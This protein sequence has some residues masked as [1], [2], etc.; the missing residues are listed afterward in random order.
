M[1]TKITHDNYTNYRDF[2]LRGLTI[3]EL[4]NTMPYCLNEGNVESRF[5]S[6]KEDFV[7]YYFNDEEDELAFILKRHITKNEWHIQQIRTV[8]ENFDKLKKEIIPL[9]E[10]ISIEKNMPIFI[11]KMRD[12]KHDFEEYLGITKVD[13]C[14]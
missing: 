9:I 3:G 8:S 1:W 6:L 10:Q 2:I 11:D 7:V 14:H 5:N 4:T 12:H 13:K